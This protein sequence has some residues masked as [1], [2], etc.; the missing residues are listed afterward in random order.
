MGVTHLVTMSDGKILTLEDFEISG[1]TSKYIKISISDASGAN[2]YLG[3]IL[4][5]DL[6]RI[7]KSL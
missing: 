3:N 6:K 4:K 7:A 2:V 5:D 1:K